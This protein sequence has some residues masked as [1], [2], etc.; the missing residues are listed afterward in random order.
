VATIRDLPRFAHRQGLN[1]HRQHPARRQSA[2][3]YQQ[4]R[5]CSGSCHLICFSR[6]PGRSHRRRPAARPH[7]GQRR[8]GE[9][10]TVRAH[11]GRPGRCLGPWGHLGRIDGGSYLKVTRDQGRHTPQAGGQGREDRPRGSDHRAESPDDLPG[12]AKSAGIPIAPLIVRPLFPLR[13]RPGT[14]VTC[15]GSGE[16]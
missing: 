11:P 6:I 13:P 14:L 5:R 12:Y 3:Q 7:P 2:G 15:T 10:G 8:S 16:Q 9:R 1:A 4:R